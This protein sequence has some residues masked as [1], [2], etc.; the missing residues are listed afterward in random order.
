MRREYHPPYS[1]SAAR[2]VLLLPLF[3]ASLFLSCRQLSIPCTFAPSTK[4]VGVSHSGIALRAP[5][6]SGARGMFWIGPIICFR[7]LPSGWAERD[8][9]G[10][11]KSGS[12]RLSL[13]YWRI[14]FKKKLSGPGLLRGS[15]EFTVV[16]IQWLIS[17]SQPL[18]YRQV[19]VVEVVAKLRFGRFD[20]LGSPDRLQTRQTAETRQTTETRQTAAST[21][22]HPQLRT[23]F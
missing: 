23:D 3:S 2:R 8:L 21:K 14:F 5:I 17:Y 13:G 6:F 15:V 12:G 9:L 19:R 11:L 20:R 10:S 7:R 1:W 18:Q 22:H 4:G 16:L